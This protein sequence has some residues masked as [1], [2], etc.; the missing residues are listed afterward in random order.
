MVLQNI[1]VSNG[2]MRAPTDENIRPPKAS[3]SRP[4]S[5]A[6]RIY[7]DASLRRR[8]RLSGTGSSRTPEQR[9]E[10]ARRRNEAKPRKPVSVN[11][12]VP[13]TIEDLDAVQSGSSS[14]LRQQTVPV[15]IPKDLPRP[16]FQEI[17]LENLFAV[18][19]DLR[20]MELAFIRDSMDG[21]GPE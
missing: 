20:G 5:L 6:S 21:A 3:S 9:A 13:P 14:T 18:E 12:T 16:E 17:S 2:A 7:Q 15:S 11:V 4:K 19:P 1:R 8:A 10:R